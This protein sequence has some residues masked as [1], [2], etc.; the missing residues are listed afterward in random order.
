MSQYEQQLGHFA[1]RLARELLQHQIAASVDNASLRDYS[2]K[3]RLTRLGTDLGNVVLYYSPKRNSYR[4]V[5]QELTAHHYDDYILAA[6]ER[7]AGAN[8]PAII[9]PGYSAYVDGTF[10]HGRVGYGAVVICDGAVVQE[11]FGRVLDNENSRQVAGE[12]AAVQ[13]VVRWCE[14]R[15]VP[16]INIYYDYTG[17]EQWALGRWQANMRLTQ[18]YYQFMR[19]TPVAVHFRKVQSHSGNRWNDR[20][21]ALARRGAATGGEG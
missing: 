18:Q 10:D 15:G 11:L 2:V 16:E 21:D 20:A 4:L 1:N 12:L 19:S 8:S 5:L 3:L 6:F 13:A 7:L 17:I 14:A 9:P